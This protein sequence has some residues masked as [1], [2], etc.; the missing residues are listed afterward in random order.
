LG[1]AAISYDPPEILAAFSRQ[2]GITFPLLS[3]AGSSTIKAFGI[4][5]PAVE[6]AFGPEKDDPSVVA[7]VRKYVSGGQPFPAMVGMA[8]PGT[9]MLDRR[10][11]VTSRFF[12][13]LYVERNTTSSVMT[14]F[15][16]GTV[17]VVG[18]KISTGQLDLTTFPSDA[19]ISAG[20]RFS[21]VFDISPHAGMHVYAPGAAGYKPITVTIA[22]Q[23]FV[24]VQPLRYPPSEI[25]FF[26]PLNE[27]VPVYQKPF[28]L[29][30]DVLLEAT[31]QAQ[32]A[33]QGKES[34]TITGTLEYQACDDKVCFN[35][36]TV[37]LSWTFSLRPLIRERPTAPR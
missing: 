26:K 34:L 23:P 13:E 11:R 29:I 14:R 6:W 37:P 2:R 4:L 22:P 28:R 32:T 12:E 10:G 3:D 25:Y 5:N 27:R 35:P 17:P 8:F 19:S 24:Q 20:N 7:E 16:A 18:A 30:Q 36:A 15:G 9:F 33:L 21:L 1:L 31:P